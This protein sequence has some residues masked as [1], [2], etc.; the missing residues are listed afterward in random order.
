VRERSSGTSYVRRRVIKPWPD[1]TLAA[2]A[3]SRHNDGRCHRQARKN[4][5][6]FSGSLPLVLELLGSSYKPHPSFVARLL[7]E[8]A[9]PDTEA[10]LREG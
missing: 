4:P 10:Q 2:F 6:Y 9:Q 5:P 7:L 8:F 1:L 3:N